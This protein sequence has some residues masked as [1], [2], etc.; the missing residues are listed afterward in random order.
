MQLTRVSDQAIA[1]GPPGECAIRGGG[2][3]GRARRSVL[4]GKD[5]LEERGGGCIGRGRHPLCDI[6]SG[7]CFFTGP[8]TVTPSPSRLPSLCPAS[9]SL[10]ANCSFDGICDRQSR[11]QPLGQPP[12]TAHLSASGAAP[13][14]PSLLM[15]FWG[16]GDP[17]FCVPKMARQ[18][19][20]NGESHSGGGG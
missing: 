2:G 17:K 20:S 9:L 12:P 15:H 4:P 1:H 6:P 5:V 13:E 8:W 11:P 19:C 7:C 18:D 10:T 16:A 3:A 14:I